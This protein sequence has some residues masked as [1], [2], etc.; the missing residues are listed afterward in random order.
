[1]WI[2]LAAKE[3]VKKN[4]FCIS[5]RLSY[6]LVSNGIIPVTWELH[7]CYLEYHSNGLHRSKN[8]FSK[9]PTVTSVTSSF[10]LINSNVVLV[11]LKVPLMTLVTSRVTYVDLQFGD[12]WNLNHSSDF[13]RNPTHFHLTP[14]NSNITLVTSNLNLASFNV[15]V[16]MLNVTEVTSKNLI[17]TSKSHSSQF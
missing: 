12:F 16:V 9:P 6:V 2:R 11:T 4:V 15:T 3:E 14:N 10:T 1:M 5:I 13:K 7:F 17:A 8:H